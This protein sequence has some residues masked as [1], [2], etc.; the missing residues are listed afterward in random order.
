MDRKREFGSKHYLIE[1]G[2]HVRMSSVLNFV[3]HDGECWSLRE[4]LQRPNGDQIDL[5]GNI[6][7]GNVIHI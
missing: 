1:L 6:K 2:N 4:I 7:V 5:F 3:T